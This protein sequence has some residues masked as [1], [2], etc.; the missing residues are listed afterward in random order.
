M[1][2]DLMKLTAVNRKLYTVATSP[3]LW[4]HFQ[5]VQTDPTKLKFLIT[6]KRLSQV[7]S[8]IIKRSMN[9]T[10]WSQL[11]PKLSL[12]VL[13]GVVEKFEEIDLSGVDLSKKQVVFLF[14]K[15]C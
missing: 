7:K 9:R 11:G 8:F 10:M 12:P 3:K 13:G 6:L 1:G 2:N 15:V 4:Q 14:E 5:F